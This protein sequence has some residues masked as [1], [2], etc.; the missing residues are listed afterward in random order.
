MTDE[1][2]T[3]LTRPAVFITVVQEDPA[4][5]DREIMQCRKVFI[6]DL[7]HAD[8]RREAQWYFTEIIHDLVEER[9]SLLADET[10]HE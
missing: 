5:V 6:G 3:T 10:Q 2:E 1:S 8:A 4:L 7:M 9:G